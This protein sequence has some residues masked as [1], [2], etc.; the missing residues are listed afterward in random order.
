MGSLT[1]LAHDDQ[2]QVR[3]AG[4]VVSSV[5]TTG[6]GKW[7]FETVPGFGA[8]PQDADL[9]PT[10]GG[11]AV[12]SEGK[13]YVSTEAEHGIVVFSPD[14]QFEKSL[15]PKTS[16]LHSLAVVTDGEQE[17]LIG[18]NAD[19]GQVLKLTLD[20]D[21]LLT[22][23]NEKT[24]EVPGGM[25]GSTGVT[26]GPSGQI[27][28]VCGYGSN[29]VHEFDGTGQLLKTAGGRG[30]ED[31][32]FVTCHGIALDTRGEEPLL[33]I[34]DRENRRLVHFDLALNF[35]AIHAQGLRRPCAV[36]L[37]GENAVVAELEGRVTI[38]DAQGFP[39]AFLGDQ[40]D[41]ELWAR[42]PIPVEQL[43]DGLFTSPHG[44]TWDQEGNVIVQDWNV[45]GR[46]TKLVRRNP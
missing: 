23:P 38:L 6:N 22:I 41:S 7:L 29:F 33:L 43:S 12:D 10:H 2:P 24:G 26:L 27:F 15:G 37:L 9:G 39:V 30:S 21:I 28:L 34:C 35:R 8:M 11:V 5:Q 18:A 13:V 16:R 19:D 20:G 31:G 36:S 44:L 45:T 32:Q 25:K 40:P 46:V 4:K 1:A 14:G 3:P 17:I 42:K